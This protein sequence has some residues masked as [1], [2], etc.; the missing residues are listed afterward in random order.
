MKVNEALLKTF[1][2]QSNAMEKK[3]KGFYT[4]DTPSDFYRKSEQIVVS[5]ELETA[6]ELEKIYSVIV[7]NGVK[8]GEIYEKYSTYLNTVRN[9]IEVLE[10]EKSE[11]EKIH[12]ADIKNAQ[13]VV[14]V[15]DRYLN[16]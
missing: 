6:K 13:L 15:M 1:T 3:I 7:Q 14:S 12:A 8:E 2:D 11:L 9:G 4:I 16:N 10:R 5:E